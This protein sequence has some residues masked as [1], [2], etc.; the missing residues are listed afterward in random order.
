MKSQNH[1]PSSCVA[2]I[3]SVL[4]LLAASFPGHPLFAAAPPNVILVM[5][6]DQGYGDVGAHGNPMIR[7]PHLDRLH[8][9][10]V[11]FTDFHVDPTCSP[12]RAALLTGRYSTRTG[13]WHTIM[14]RSLLFHHEQTMAEVFRANGYRTGIFGKWHLGDNYPMRPQDRGF[15]E[16]L[17][18]GGGGVGQTPDFWDNDYFDD[19]FFHNDRWEKFTG[20]CTDVFFDGALKFI[21]QHRTRPFFIYIPTNVPHGPYNVP[22]RYAKPYLDQGVSQP[23]ANFYGMIENFDE[24][25][26]RLLARLKETGLE[27]NTLVIFMTDNGTAAGVARPGRGKGKGKAAATEDGWEGFNAGMRGQKGSH[28]DGGHRVPFFIRW[29]GG[30]IDGGRDVN[31][32]AAHL[33]VLPTLVELCGLKFTPK[34][35]LD[36]RSLVPLLRGPASDWAE[37][38]LFVH[39]QRQEIPPKWE[40]SV[41]LTKRWR[42]VEGKELYDIQADPGQTKDV[43]AQHADV[44]A[45]L[46]AD[47][48]K[49]WASLE[50]SFTNF[51]CIVIGSDQENPAHITCHD[52]HSDNVP[53]HHGMIQQAPKANGWW[54]IEVAKAGRYEFT[55]RQQ[56]EVAG[57]PIQGSQARIRVGDAEASAA[58]PAG[59][60]AVKLTL[61]LQAGPQ[62]MQTWFTGDAG[63]ERGAFYIDARRLD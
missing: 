31:T 21:G 3:L 15:D 39:V 27:R 26:G 43:A 20:Y 42:L 1:S 32:L 24:N 51:G 7:T 9:G 45:K 14:G 57:F 60:T 36:G 28:Y 38:T 13:V 46:R 18:H 29:P 10:S 50:P 61:D 23:M 40:R 17:I 5:T 19:T 49:W 63:T 11:R 25:M 62:R 16:V 37:R 56:P 54:M 8:A 22:E 52:W 2:T 4:A 48:E 12:T 30:R 34:N 33:D 47:Y 6:D 41:A 55:L 35:P 53:W 58:I 44:V 59:T